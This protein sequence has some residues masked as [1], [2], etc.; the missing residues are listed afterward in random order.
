MINEVPFSE[1]R[2]LLRNQ[3]FEP[4]VN[5]EKFVLALAKFLPI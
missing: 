5:V 2:I 4:A 3:Y 1:F